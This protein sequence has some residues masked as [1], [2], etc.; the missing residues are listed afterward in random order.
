MPYRHARHSNPA[1]C[2]VTG[3]GP[4]AELLFTGVLDFMCSNLPLSK[5]LIGLISVS[6]GTNPIAQTAIST[7]Q[8]YGFRGVAVFPQGEPNNVPYEFLSAVDID[9]DPDWFSLLTNY[10][11]AGA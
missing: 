8:S 11:V 7:I 6:T 9:S 5:T 4:D 2:P 1:L 10:F 3:D